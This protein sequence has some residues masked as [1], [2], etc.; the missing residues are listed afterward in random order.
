MSRGVIKMG[1]RE[2]ALLFNV[3]AM[4]ELEKVVG[5]PLDLT[6]L[7]QEL[8]A[9]LTDRHVLTEAAYILAMAGER[10]RGRAADVDLAWFKSRLKPGA[11]MRLYTKVI[12]ALT[13]GLVMET[14]E[15]SDEDEVDVV[16]AELKKK[17]TA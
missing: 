10:A 8:F 2:F 13:D 16:L 3:E 17:P 11:Q 1:G 4:D 6:N 15:G 14:S 5:G 12:E 7:Q 9:K